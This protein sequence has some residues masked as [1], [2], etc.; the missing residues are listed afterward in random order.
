MKKHHLYLIANAIILTGCT[1]VITPEAPEARGKIATNLRAN[2]AA[3]T[4]KVAGNQFDSSDEVGLYMKSAGQALAVTSVYSNA[5]N[6]LMSLSGQ[7]LVSNPPVMYPEIGSVDFI[8]YYPYTAAVS[9]DYTIDVNVAGQASALPTEVLYSNN[10][11]RQVPTTSPVTLN[12]QYSLAKLEV[13][14]IGGED[15][16]L[17]EA[18]FEDMTATIDGMFTQG[19]LQLTSGEITNRQVTQQ[20]TLYKKDSDD[21][22]ATFEALVLP[23][24][25]ADGEITFAFVANGITYQHKRTVNYDSHSLYKLTFE[26]NFSSPE[27]TAVLLSTLIL[28]RDEFPVENIPINVLPENKPIFRLVASSTSLFAGDE[29]T[30]TIRVENN[31]GRADV[32]TLYFNY[33][34]D[35]FEAIDYQP[36]IGDNSSIN[37]DNPNHSRGHRVAGIGLNNTN[38]SFDYGIITFRVKNGIEAGNYSMSFPSFEG[39]LFESSTVTYENED[40]VLLGVM[41]SLLAKPEIKLTPTSTVL[42]V[43]DEFDVTI[44]IK[45]NPGIFTGFRVDIIYDKNVFEPVSYQESSE[46]NFGLSMDNPDHPEGHRVSGSAATGAIISNSSFTCGIITL[47]VKEDATLG[48]Y[49]MNISSSSSFT[50]SAIRYENNS[51][52]LTGTSLTIV[53]IP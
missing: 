50:S 28:P 33:D 10:V 37:S 3:S 9:N 11:T 49:D 51:I 4:L 42:N 12:F 46:L 48:S 29:F 21:N 1:V 40:I 32:L 36:A 20:I 52:T 53:N 27:P 43:G 22:S 25:V 35:I 26:L 16:P 38:T 15:S 8:A 45:N 31:P 7:D 14:V 6:V 19:K 24:V 13:K 47:K 39:I 30:V 17:V 44:D 18:D 23:H 5:N 34:K 41:L 2:I